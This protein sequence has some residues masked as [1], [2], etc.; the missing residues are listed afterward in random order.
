MLEGGGEREEYQKPLR[1][2]AKKHWFELKE[3]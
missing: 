3:N 1:E 2:Q